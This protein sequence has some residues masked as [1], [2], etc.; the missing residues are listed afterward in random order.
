MTQQADDCVVYAA[1]LA[2]DIAHLSISD[3]L[4][5]ATVLMRILVDI[6]FSK[7][8]R[9]MVWERTVR[10]LQSTPSPGDLHEQTKGPPSSRSHH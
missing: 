5:V 8:Q 9:D 6:H 2:A 3:Q 10:V 4:T 7:E 1:E